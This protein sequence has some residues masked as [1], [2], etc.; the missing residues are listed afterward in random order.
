MNIVMEFYSRLIETLEDYKYGRLSGAF[1]ACGG[2]ILEHAEKLKDKLTPKFNQE[3]INQLVFQAVDVEGDIDLV[4]G[5][6]AGAYVDLCSIRH[7]SRSIELIERLQNVLAEGDLIL[8]YLCR[9]IPQKGGGA[10]ITLHT[11]NL[12]HFKKIVTQHYPYTQKVMGPNRGLIDED[13]KE[14]CLE[15]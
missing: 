7:C 4:D 10:T 12:E 11:S 14:L 1:H 13:G 8:V 5:F 2:T 9:I 3:I 15:D 6:M